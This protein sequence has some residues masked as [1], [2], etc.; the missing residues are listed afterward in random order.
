MLALVAEVQKEGEGRVAGSESRE[1]LEHCTGQHLWRWMGQCGWRR[2]RCMHIL[3][4][5]DVLRRGFCAIVYVCV[6]MCAH[7][8]GCV[9]VYVGVCMTVCNNCSSN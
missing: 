5:C 3:T 7:A 8:C 2:Y 9:C 1:E 4:Y 6:C